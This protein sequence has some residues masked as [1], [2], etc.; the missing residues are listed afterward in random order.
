VPGAQRQ[1][2]AS[3][4]SGRCNA[5]AGD[6]FAS[7]PRGGD[8]CI[9]AQVLHDWND[10]QCVTILK[11]CHA[12]MPADGRILVV[13]T[14]IMPAT[15]SSVATLADLHMLVV[16]GGRERTEAEYRDLLAQAGFTLTRVIPTQSPAHVIEGV[17]V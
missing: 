5:V 2:E 12:A 10:Q 3:G 8:A 7:V 4:L 16:T 1:I 9:L 11:N 15:D 14:V 6:F 17:R 13:E